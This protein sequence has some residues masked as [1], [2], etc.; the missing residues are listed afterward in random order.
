MNVWKMLAITFAWW[1]CEG[2][3]SYLRFVNGIYDGWRIRGYFILSTSHPHFIF[4]YQLNFNLSR[5]FNSNVSGDSFLGVTKGISEYIYELVAHVR[6][7]SISS[8]AVI[9]QTAGCQSRERC[10][11]AEQSLWNQLYAVLRLP[12]IIFK[13]KFYYLSVPGICIRLSCVVCSNLEFY[14]TR[15]EHTYTWSHVCQNFI[16][17][18]LCYRCG[19]PP[20]PPAENSIEFTRIVIDVIKQL[21]Q[22]EITIVWWVIVRVKGMSIGNSP[23]DH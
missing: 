20:P 21:A 8:P 2:S 19:P 15:T 1:W 14:T 4:F 16:H 5:S 9:I 22:H 12:Y 11:R 13:G 17:S 23:Y 7:K 6:T 3:L 10:H 18:I